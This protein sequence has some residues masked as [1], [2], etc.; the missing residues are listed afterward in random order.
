MWLLSEKP[1]KKLCFIKDTREQAASAGVLYR[2]LGGVQLSGRTCGDPSKVGDAVH[3]AAFS[4]IR[5]TT[6]LC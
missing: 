2:V 4:C 6:L 3:S 1:P 5:I